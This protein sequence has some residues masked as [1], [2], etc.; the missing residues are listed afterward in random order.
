MLSAVTKWRFPIAFSLLILLSYFPYCLKIYDEDLN[1]ILA[2]YLLLFA[3][4]IW[5]V[6]TAKRRSIELV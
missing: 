1:V 3:F 2:E 5:E 4:M 6:R